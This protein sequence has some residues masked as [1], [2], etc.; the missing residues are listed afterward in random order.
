MSRTIEAV[1]AAADAAREATGARP[2]VALVTGT[3]L[4]GLADALE[5]AREV[6]YGD[7][8]GF[9]AAT[10]EGH[11]GRLVAGRLED[12]PVAVLD[13]RYHRYEGHDLREVG[14]PVRVVREL[15][16][17]TLVVTAACGCMHPLWERG[18]L[19]LISDHINLMG[20]NP[21][22]GPN[23]EEQGPRFPDM[24]EA[25]D[26]GLRSLARTVAREEGLVLREG[27]YAGV[28]G[29]NLE[30]AAEY[31][32]L[33]TA[34]ADVVGMSTVPEVIVA[35]HAGM[36]TLGVGIVTD[37]ALPDALEPVD[38]EEA[39]ATARSTAPDLARV[40]RGVLAR[41]GSPATA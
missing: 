4:G 8:P 35:N 21:L 2:E 30:T 18:D 12:R 20:D 17:G 23:V 10:V 28:T 25:Y 26:G 40:I 6:P 29:P 38:V 1:R 24:S 36:R 41:T 15:G 34:G 33:R 5:D 9:P 27:V 3:G 11:A 13:G 7:L 37:M 16:A 39:M 32:M 14:F 19:V 31:R 22:V